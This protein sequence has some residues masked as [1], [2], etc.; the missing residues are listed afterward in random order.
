MIPPTINSN[1]ISRK[2]VERIG[3]ASV[4]GSASCPRKNDIKLSPMKDFGSNAK[5]S[6]A[7]Y[8]AINETGIQT[9]YK[10]NARAPIARIGTKTGVNKSK[11]RPVERIA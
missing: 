7:A 5:R 11:P 9:M 3:E 6:D 10:V 1:K 4:P 2:A 8:M